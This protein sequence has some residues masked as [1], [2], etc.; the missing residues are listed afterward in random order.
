MRRST[1]LRIPSPWS[2][3]E[4]D[5]IPRLYWAWFALYRTTRIVRHRFGAHDWEFVYADPIH[6][7][8]KVLQFGFLRCSWCGAVKHEQ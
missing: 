7:T 4:R 8:E 6:T 2:G 1:A 5:P 3:D